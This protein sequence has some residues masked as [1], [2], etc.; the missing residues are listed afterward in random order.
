MACIPAVDAYLA[1]PTLPENMTSGAKRILRSTAHS[2]PMTDGKVMVD[3]V[4]IIRRESHEFNI[5][6]PVEEQE[7]EQKPQATPQREKKRPVLSLG[8]CFN[9]DAD[10]F[11]LFPLPS[12]R[13][14]PRNSPLV[15]PAA[16]QTNLATPPTPSPIMRNGSPLS[17]CCSTESTHREE[18]PQIAR[19]VPTAELPHQQDVKV[20]A[21]HRER[22][23]SS[24]SS[25][26]K[27]R[28]P[29]LSTLG[30][31]ITKGSFAVIKGLSG[32]GSPS[33]FTG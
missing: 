5:R 6:D 16:S 30:T 19:V 2:K 26:S 23:G 33:T 21:P 10:E 31:S 7:Q 27:T 28:R 32:V 8:I 17:T 22:S 1:S 13:E 14:S 3:E 24:S 9:D 12:P 18:R 29:S 15:S 20:P 11:E 4:D 25:G